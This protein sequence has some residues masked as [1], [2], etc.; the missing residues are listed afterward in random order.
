MENSKSNQSDD[1]QKEQPENGSENSENP[2]ADDLVSLE[3]LVNVL[4]R[5]GICTAEELFEEERT[6]RLYLSSVKDISI[7]KTD[8]SAD[9][10]QGFSTKGNRSW[11][12]REMSK[13]RWTRKLGATFFGWEW[14]KVRNKRNSKGAIQV[15]NFK[16]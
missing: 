13:R 8:G 10:H 5:N 15:E 9:S 7:V 11:L 4:I 14:K 1:Y 16:K 3:A 12:K 2:V 6:R